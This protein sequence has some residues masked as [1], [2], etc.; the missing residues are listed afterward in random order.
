[1][2]KNFLASLFLNPNSFNFAYIF[3]NITTKWYFYVICL[4]FI[5]LIDYCSICG[6]CGYCG[7]EL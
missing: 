5:I 7:V 2:G 4:A 3:K 1:M 6:G